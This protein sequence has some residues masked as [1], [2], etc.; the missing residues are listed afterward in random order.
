MKRLELIACEAV[1]AE[2][3]AGLERSVKDIEYTLFPRIEG[4]GKRIRK[5]GTQTWPELNFMLLSYLND[6]D[7]PAA[8][9][10]IADV[11]RRFPNEGIFAAVVNAWRINA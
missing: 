9:K 6:S 5:D 8:E 4:K 1:Q 7:I 11:A 10:A 3:I 2:L